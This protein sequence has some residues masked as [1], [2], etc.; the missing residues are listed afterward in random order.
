M[1][2]AYLYNRPVTEGAKMDCEKTRADYDK[3]NRME[4]SALLGVMLRAGD[5]VCVRA[6]SDFG[7]GAGSTRIQDQIRERGATIEVWPDEKAVKVRGRPKR[8][9]PTVENLDRICAS[10]YSPV[11]PSHVE[12]IAEEELG[13]RVN[14]N[15]INT[16]CGPRHGKA[17]PEYKDPNKRET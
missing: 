1:R 9:H 15:W 8:I 17:R 6:L 14:R 12:D 11:P 4:L 3:T 2:I 10:W 5:V 16:H 13:E 7:N